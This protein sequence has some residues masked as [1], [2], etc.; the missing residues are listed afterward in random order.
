MKQTALKATAIITL[1]GAIIA[2]AIAQAE[3]SIAPSATHC[4]AESYYNGETLRVRNS[5]EQYINIIRVNEAEGEYSY[6]IINSVPPEW[7]WRTTDSSNKNIVSMDACYGTIGDKNGEPLKAYPIAD[8]ML[9]FAEKVAKESRFSE[10]DTA[11]LK[12]QMT[13]LVIPAFVSL[14]PKDVQFLFN[15]TDSIYQRP[16]IR[17]LYDG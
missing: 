8:A 9:R 15:M 14:L 16:T 4:L 6:M 13:E 3:T 5:C 11:M 1:T 7:V 10:E 2:T 12:A 17:C